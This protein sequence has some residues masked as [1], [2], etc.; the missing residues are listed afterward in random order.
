MKNFF[1]RLGLKVANL[2]SCW[3]TWEHLEPPRTCCAFSGFCGGVASDTK[4]VLPP[5]TGPSLFT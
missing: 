5:E 3:E 2:L 4:Q 1:I